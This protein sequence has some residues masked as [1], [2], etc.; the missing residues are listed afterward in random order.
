MDG[1][2]GNAVGRP[3]PESE[4]FDLPSVLAQL[5]TQESAEQRA[6]V[7]T[8]R[9]ALSD[10]PDACLP[11]VPKL[12]SLLEQPELEFHETIAACLADLASESPADVVPSTDKI[13]AV[14]ADQPDRPATRELLRCLAN[15][16]V[17]RPDVVADHAETIATI[18]EQRQGVTPEGLDL[19]QQ[20]SIDHPAAVE[21]AFPVLTGALATDPEA[22]GPRALS[23]LGRLAHSE[24]PLPTL[25]FLE[26]AMAFVDH[27]DDSLRNNAIGCLADI[28]QHRPAAV[29]PAIAD[30]AAVL[31]HD[32]PGTRANATVVVARLA[33][34]TGRIVDAAREPVLESLGDDHERVRANACVAIGHARLE[35]ATERLKALARE[36]PDRSVRERAD[37][38]LDR[39]S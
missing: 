1:E 15:V 11:T 10:S 2:G 29:E 14:A 32:D 36:D 25:D 24:T 38:A 18:L 13:V 28:A 12:R 31:D 21:P 33:E 8:I 23:A 4:T 26:E 5:D 20:L 17:D 3:S 16:A 19:V 27:E 30:I 9:G 22:Y 6:A 7:E 39:V 34:E 35:P 37:W